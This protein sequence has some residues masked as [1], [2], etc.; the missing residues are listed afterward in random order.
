[1][2]EKIATGEYVI[3]VAVSGITIF[4]R[5]EQPGGEILGFAFPDDGTIVML[6]G[7]GIPKEA[8][9]P[10]S[11]KLFV[12]YALSNAGQTLLGKGGL[13]PYRDDVAESDVRYTYQGIAEQIGA[14]N[15]IEAG[16]DQRLI[17]EAPAFVEKWNAALQ[18]R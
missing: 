4:P 17:T 3:G 8:A 11:A 10:N 5:L 6:R 16:F 1:M 14:D 15:V 18:G 2:N 13:V 9:N 12:D 7:L